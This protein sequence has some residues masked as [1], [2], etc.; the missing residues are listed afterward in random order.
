MYSL[1]D[2]DVSMT[3]AVGGKEQGRPLGWLSCAHSG[4]K[5]LSEARAAGFCSVAEFGQ[6]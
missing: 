5:L 1:W 3:P 4:L 2:A 6:N